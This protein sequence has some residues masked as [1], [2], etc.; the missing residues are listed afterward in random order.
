[1]MRAALEVSQLFGA[2]LQ[3]N[4]RVR[5][6]HPFTDKV[7]RL[8]RHSCSSNLEVVVRVTRLSLTLFCP[9]MSVPP[10]LYTY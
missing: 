2:G 6:S 9:V 7:D 5:D 4:G 3:W 1:M 10:S 8:E